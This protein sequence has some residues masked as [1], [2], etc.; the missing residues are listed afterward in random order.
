MPPPEATPDPPVVDLAVGMVQ[1]LPPKLQAT[2]NPL[3]QRMRSA[4]G[5]VVLL[6]IALLSVTVPVIGIP[7]IVFLLENLGIISHHA[8]RRFFDLCTGYWITM[9]TV[10]CAKK[11]EQSCF[12][13]CGREVMSGGDIKLREP[14]LALKNVLPILCIIYSHHFIS[15]K[16][17]GF[18]SQL[19]FVIFCKCL[20][21]LC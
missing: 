15:L 18:L 16:V 4:L 10:S 19:F 3:Q 8:S 20:V 1:P 17:L 2:L 14:F 9:M 12:T 11:N 5:V 21:S 7:P 13:C 6:C